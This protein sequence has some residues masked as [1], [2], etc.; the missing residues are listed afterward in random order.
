MIMRRRGSS[1]V[2]FALVAPLLLLLL[3]GVLNYAMALRVAIAVSDAARAGA[4]YG[5]LTPANAADTAGMSA[6][7]RNS[8][9]ELTGMVAT[10]SKICKCSG[11]S[12]SCAASCAGP[13]AVYAQVTASATAPNWFRYPG[14]PFSGAVAATATMRA[15]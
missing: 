2:E 9:P 12:V 10:G 15:K 5:S 4:Q 1:L 8:A 7:A 3:A 13:L 6:A 14:L 11:A